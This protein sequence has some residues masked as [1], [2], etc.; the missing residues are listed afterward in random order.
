MFATRYW[1]AR[2][3]TASYWPKVGA[4]P[5]VPAK[6]P[7]PGAWRPVPIIRVLEYAG[8]VG[9]AIEAAARVDFSVTNIAMVCES[10]IRTE[11]LSRA[12]AKLGESKERKRLFREDE[13]IL[14]ILLFD[15]SE[16]TGE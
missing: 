12:R 14:E 16:F 9:L 8:E 6:L 1:P 15:E 10:Q 4:V 3:F 2:Y 7:G 13:E 5:V 11:L